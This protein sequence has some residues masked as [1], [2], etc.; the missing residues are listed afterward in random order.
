MRYHVRQMTATNKAA[1][2]ELIGTD[3]CVD[4]R[5]SLNSTPN[6]IFKN[7][8]S[9][10]EKVGSAKTD[11]SAALFEVFKY[12]GGYTSPANAG[13]MW[14]AHRSVRASSGRCVMPVTP[15]RSPIRRLT[16]MALMIRLSASTCHLTGA[17]VAR[18]MSSSL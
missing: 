15:T 1:L 11:Y 14:Q 3:S 2:Q 17:A 12:F 4:G 5:N 10:A 16:S 6:C 9:P 13:L 18:R 7:F 8:D